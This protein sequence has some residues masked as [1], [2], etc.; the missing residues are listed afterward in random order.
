MELDIESVCLSKFLTFI[1]FLEWHGLGKFLWH[2][3]DSSTRMG[4][5]E[6]V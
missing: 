1:L 2:K 3:Q 4:G 6:I 5:E